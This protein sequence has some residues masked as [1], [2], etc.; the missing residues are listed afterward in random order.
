MPFDG[1]KQQHRDAAAGN[2][3]VAAGGDQ[4]LRLLGKQPLDVFGKLFGF[5]SLQ[6]LSR[7]EGHGVH[8]GDALFQPVFADLVVKP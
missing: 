8:A 2:K 7:L 6:N 3:H 1:G 4:R 5:V